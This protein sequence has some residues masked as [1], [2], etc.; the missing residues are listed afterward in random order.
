MRCVL[1][2]GVVRL[3]EHEAEPGLVDTPRHPF[4][5]QVDART[6]RFEQILGQAVAGLRPVQRQNGD[7]GDVLA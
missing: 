6:Q 2:R 1:H 4:R 7:T 3:G 5:I